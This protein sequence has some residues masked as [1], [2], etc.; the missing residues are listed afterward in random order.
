MSV[1][2]DPVK[3]RSAPGLA[4]QVALKNTENIDMLLIVEKTIRGEICHAVYRYAKSNN[5]CMKHY[6]KNKE[7]LHLK[8]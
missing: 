7:S 6:N 4:W 2:L 8:Y 5:K 1:K 3:F